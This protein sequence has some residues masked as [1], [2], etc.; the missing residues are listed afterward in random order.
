MGLWI[1]FLWWWRWE[2]QHVGENEYCWG[3][4]SKG[5]KRQL[6]IFL[7]W[8]LYFIYSFLWWL[9]EVQYVGD[10][11]LRV[12]RGSC[13][14]LDFIQ[15]FIWDFN[16][17]SGLHKWPAETQEVQPICIFTIRYIFFFFQFLLFKGF[18]FFNLN[19]R[20]IERLKK[21]ACSLGSEYAQSKDWV[22]CVSW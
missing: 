2:V 11:H 5:C 12:A 17:C 18:I 6:D 7:S 20:R 19:E 21:I 22:I 16:L 10:L 4:A 1:V 9:W 8:I 13:Y 3:L 15:D 14:Y